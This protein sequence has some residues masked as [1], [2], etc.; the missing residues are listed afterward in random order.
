MLIARVS[1]VANSQ[2]KVRGNARILAKISVPQWSG[3]RTGV[4]DY[5]HPIGVGLQ[6]TFQMIWQLERLVD[7]P[8]S[9]SSAKQKLGDT[10]RFI[11]LE[12]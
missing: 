3:A 4:F 5:G 9:E 8:K 7:P 10:D 2:Y 6:Q 1:S 12:V 11:P